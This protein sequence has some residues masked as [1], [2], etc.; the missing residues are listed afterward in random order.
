[1]L[2]FMEISQY[3]K[4]SVGHVIM[5][6]RRKKKV[7]LKMSQGISNLMITFFSRKYVFSEVSGKGIQMPK[8]QGSHASCSGS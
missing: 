3:L 1:M 4:R 5:G 8:L 2:H 7:K 6:V